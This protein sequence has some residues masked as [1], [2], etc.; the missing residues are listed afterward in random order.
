MTTERDGTRPNPPLLGALLY[1]VMNLP[2]GI[3]SFVFVV[4]M[5]SVG[6]GTVIVWVGLAVLAIAV[7]V[8]RGFAQAER[9]RVHVMLGTYIAVPYRPDEGRRWTTRIKDPAT[10]KDMA[11]CVLLLPIGIAEF[12]LMVTFWATSLW[13]VTLPVCWTWLPADW[14]PVMWDEPLFSI[15]SWPE[16]LPWAALGVLVLAMAIA[17]TKALGTL[18]A[19]YARSMLGPS[20]RHIS[21]LEQLSTAGAI[22]WSTEW[23]ATVE[24]IYRPVTR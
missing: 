20:R 2:I 8:W 9:A 11:Y 13:L 16:T 21:K 7:L 1:L 5:L 10:W 3:A 14:R 24:S 18:H 22:D 12:T 15:D 19:R 4:T 23:P 6:V 17:L